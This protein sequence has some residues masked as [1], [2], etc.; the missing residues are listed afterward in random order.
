M[1][2]LIDSDYT[3]LNEKLAR[4]YSLTNLNVTGPKCGGHAPKTIPAAADPGDVLTVT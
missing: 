3:F 4:H 2:D 1:K